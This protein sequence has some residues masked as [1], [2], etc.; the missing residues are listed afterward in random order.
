MYS[1]AATLYHAATGRVP[2]DA[3]TVE[4][5]VWAHVKSKLTPPRKIISDLSKDTSNAICKAMEKDPNNRFQSYDQFIMDLEAS[6]SRLLVK[7]FR[8]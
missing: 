2:F 3:P 6:R 8:R 4:E 5:T 7:R 1:L